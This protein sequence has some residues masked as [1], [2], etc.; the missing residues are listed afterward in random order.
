MKICIVIPAFNEAKTIGE[1][2]NAVKSCGS[3]IL[4]VNDGSADD[5]ENIAKASGAD[6]ITF[7][8]NQGKGKALKCGFDYAA[9]KGYDAVITM[10]GDGQHSPGDLVNIIENSGK[11]E[12]GIVVGNRMANPE[13]M[14][15]S[16]FGTNLFMSFIISLICR[17]N[18]PDTQCGYRLIKTD[19]LKRTHLFS[20]NYEIESEVLIKASR[21]GYKIISVP[22]KSVYEGQ[23]SFINPVVDSWRFLIML[24]KVLIS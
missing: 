19:I 21:L 8:K 18:I 23:T 20:S 3:D 2:I 14:P 22:I 24:F 16:R 5:T 6:C 17:Q 9:Q 13:K 10:D 12:I 4:V 7:R 11:N 15:L 1:V